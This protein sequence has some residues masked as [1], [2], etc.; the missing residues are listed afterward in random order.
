MLLFRLLALTLRRSK[1]DACSAAAARGEGAACAACADAAS[2]NTPLT[3]LL[4]SRI[5]AFA[6]GVGASMA[7]GAGVSAAPTLPSP[8]LP[9]TGPDAGAA[10]T[11]LSS[12]PFSSAG[13]ALAP[14]AG[15]KVQGARS[16]AIFRASRRSARA[17]L[18]SACESREEVVG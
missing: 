18:D 8:L 17:A 4:D 12:T 5:E 3:E 13:C 15:A 14:T 7:R 11:A 16:S 1:D 10:A 2:A 9:P 6:G